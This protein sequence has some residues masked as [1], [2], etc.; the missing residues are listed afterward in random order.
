MLNIQ[1]WRRRRERKTRNHQEE[2]GNK[3]EEKRNTNNII[4]THRETDTRTQNEYTD[5]VECHRTAAISTMKAANQPATEMADTIFLKK[6]KEKKKQ[7][8]KSTTN[9]PIKVSGNSP[10]MNFIFTNK[11][12]SERSL[13]LAMKV[14]FQFCCCFSFVFSHSFGIRVSLFYLTAYI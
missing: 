11:Y 9:T 12:Q 4:H 6:K 2:H 8:K 3:E 10:Q 1:H 13:C 14:A 7:G 5:T